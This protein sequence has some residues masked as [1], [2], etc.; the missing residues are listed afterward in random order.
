M[1][2][3]LE[4]FIDQ[5]A[6]ADEAP[7]PEEVKEAPQETPEPE[8]KAK[9]EKEQDSTPEPEV[10]ESEEGEK[11]TK[12]QQAA[13]LAERRKRQEL[14]KRLAEIEASQREVPRRPD[15]FEDQDGAFNHVQQ[16]LQSEM[17]NMRLE[18]AQEMMRDAHPDYDELE[19][20]FIEMARENP[21]LQAELRK[22]RNPAR[23]AYETARKAREAQELQNI[24]AYKEKLKAEMRAELEAEIRAMKEADEGKLSKKRQAIQPS[25]TTVKGAQTSIVDEDDS[26]Q[27]LTRLG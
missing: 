16:Q 5:V 11:W 10:N 20:E 12:A 13:V 7:Q 4:A 22:S 1:A 24:D 15:V 26:L 19:A 25:L 2:N 8:V 21:V 14:E 3:D 9:A 27:S 18:F 17:V 6:G 23:Y